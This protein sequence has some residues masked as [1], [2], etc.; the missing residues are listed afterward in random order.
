MKLYHTTK[1]ENLESIAFEGLLPS[2]DTTAYG[3]QRESKERGVYGFTNIEDAREFARDN[4]WFDA[5][6]LEFDTE[7]AEEVVI[8]PEYDEGIA[9]IAIPGMSTIRGEVVEIME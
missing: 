6:I 5:A 7:S 3:Y 2:G 9:Y 8:D 1:S 4:G